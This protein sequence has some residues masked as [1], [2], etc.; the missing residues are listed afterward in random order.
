MD[1]LVA[2]YGKS[3]FPV[4]NTYGLI[5]HRTHPF[6]SHPDVDRIEEEVQQLNVRWENVGAQV[7]ER[8]KAA[9]RALQIQMVF[10]SEYENE[11]AWLDRVSAASL[12]RR[13]ES[14]VSLL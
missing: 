14:C 11:M 5:I 7:A 9:E 6:F 13:P 12:R 4:L 3:S 10:R 8:L 1:M 2:E